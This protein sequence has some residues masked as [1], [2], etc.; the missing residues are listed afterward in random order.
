MNRILHFYITLAFAIISNAIS[1]QNYTDAE[2]DRL[3]N[4]AEFWEK[5]GN[6]NKTI[7]YKEKLVDLYRKNYMQDL[8]LILRNIANTYGSYGS[9]SES[10]RSKSE[11]YFIE[12]L[13][14]ISKRQVNDDNL[15]L[16]YNCLLDMVGWNFERKEYSKI[17]NTIQNY[18]DFLIKNS[19]KIHKEEV[20]NIRKARYNSIIQLND[21]CQKLKNNSE[22]ELASNIMD[23]YV[24][25]FIELLRKDSLVEEISNLCLST[26]WQ[27]AD[28]L[29]HVEEKK[30]TSIE[31]YELHNKFLRNNLEFYLRTG[32]SIDYLWV[33][34]RFLANIYFD[35]GNRQKDIEISERIVNEARIHNDSLLLSEKLMDLG[36]SYERNHTLEGRNNSQPIFEESLNILTKLQI[37]QDV[38]NK[39]LRVLELLL[40]EYVLCGHYNKV[41]DLCSSYK[42][43]LNKEYNSEGESLLIE[44]LRWK[45]SAYHHLSFSPLGSREESHV[46]NNK[47]LDY[48]QRKYGKAS[49]QYLTQLR[50]ASFAYLD[51]DTLELDSI[52]SEGV[53]LWNGLMQNKYTREYSS[54]LV[55]YF[56]YLL[57]R[58]LTERA[59]SVSKKIEELF[60]IGSIDFHTVINYYYDY[61]INEYNNCRYD[62]AM[63]YI[64]KALFECEKHRDNSEIEEKTAMILCQKSNIAFCQGKYDIAKECAYTAYNIIEK[65]D[66]PNL[67]KSDILYSLSYLM[68]NFGEKEKSIEMSMEAFNISYKC[69]G[70]YTPL[71][72][73]SSTINRF[74]PK[75]QINLIDTL[76]IENFLDNPEVVDLFITKAA[77]YINLGIFDCAEV[78]LTQAEKYL[79]KFI[80]DAFY[81][82]GDRK[83]L[84]KSSLLYNRGVLESWRKNYNKAISYF[85]D[86]RNLLETDTSLPWLNTMYALVKD[87]SN[88]SIETKKALEYLVTMSENSIWL[89]NYLLPLMR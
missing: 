65:N 33:M 73:V 36:V 57:K 43:V 21:S 19:S 20:A 26:V 31:L 35:L 52:Y 84:I 46:I 61:S 6:V 50:L 79:N 80:E 76:H 54:F 25:D 23:S 89:T 38:D 16:Y 9:L 8:P 53:K 67:L 15:T 3:W 71:D 7:E 2:L 70:I 5:A 32:M 60:S 24:P 51:C 56:N 69:E 74:D 83:K 72:K 13:D 34:E 64:E 66:N 17:L 55:T 41:I 82:K 68:D 28:I 48:Q 45:S 1:A 18:H 86:Y 62:Q 37:N 42:D 22:Y 81:Q 49:V 11:D 88:F 44:I 27:Y 75:T 39:I 12:A 87:S 78:C 40:G 10:F 14:L 30:E 4:Q 77:A 29:S 58:G 85:T 47:I 63:E 59:S